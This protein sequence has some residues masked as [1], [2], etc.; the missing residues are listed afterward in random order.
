M[1][2]ETYPDAQLTS[3]SPGTEDASTPNTANPALTTLAP[4]PTSMNE[5]A[6]PI[7]QF[8]SESTVHGGGFAPSARFFTSS[9]NFVVQGGVF[10]SQTHI[11]N[12]SPALPSGMGEILHHIEWVLMLQR[13]FEV[14]PLG[15][16]DLRNEMC[17]DAGSDTVYRKYEHG[18]VRKVYSAWIHGCKSNMTVAVYL[19]DNAEEEWRQDISKYSGLRHPNLIQLFGTVSSSGLHAA[20]YHAGLHSLLLVHTNL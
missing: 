1:D 5:G 19:R 17:L 3:E 20:E 9:R 12:V 14:I 11:H 6:L 8:S 16:L 7:A 13:D 18:S 15:H 2:N 10:T 4:P